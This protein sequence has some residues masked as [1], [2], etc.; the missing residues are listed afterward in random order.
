MS[1]HLLE[2]MNRG[3]KAR[4]I[5]NIFVCS[6]LVLAALSAISALS[7]VFGYCVMRGAPSL[8]WDFFVNLPKP[9]GESGGGMANSLLG[10]FTLVVLACIRNSIGNLYR[11]IPC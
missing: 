9:V 1:R 7:L 4:K 8:N 11:R 3:Y 10:S 5:K 2:Y 6:I